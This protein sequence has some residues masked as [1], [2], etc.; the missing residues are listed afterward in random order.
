MSEFLA[1][2]EENFD[3]EVFTGK[4]SLCCWSLALPGAKPCKSLEPLLLHLAEE[5][6]GRVSLAKLGCG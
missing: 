6:E 2:N 1:I 5:W 4:K 3:Q